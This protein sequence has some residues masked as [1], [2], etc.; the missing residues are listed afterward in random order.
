MGV[1]GQGR[2]TGQREGPGAGQGPGRAAIAH[3]WD[4]EVHKDSEISVKT[5]AF[6]SAKNENANIMLKKLAIFI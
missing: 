2:E 4:N 1:H 6:N 5:F 3:P